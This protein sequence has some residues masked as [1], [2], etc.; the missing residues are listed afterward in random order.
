MLSTHLKS[1]TT[2]ITVL[3][4]FFFSTCSLYGQSTS[5]E[6][7]WKTSGF[8]AD[9]RKEIFV[10]AYEGYQKGNFKKG[11]L[12]II[13]FKKPAA[14]DRF[15]VLDLEKKK[16]VIKSLVAHGQ[17]TGGNYAKHFSNNSGSHMSSLGFFKTA[18]TYS[19]KHGYSLRLDGLD[20][21]INDKA[22][23]RAIVIHGADYVSREF[24]KKH[25]RLG[26]SW[27]EPALP[28]ADSKAIID[29]IKNGVCLFVSS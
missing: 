9:V 11:L 18:E 28:R 20:K 7:I 24:I 12:V 8:R 10:K 23:E 13:D 19:G 4:S 6:E 15:F 14:A 16:T 3:V 21:G 2:L 17:A 29:K 1:Y 22:R 27:G 26:R 5:A 25:G